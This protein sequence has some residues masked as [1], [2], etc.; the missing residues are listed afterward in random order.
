[1][2]IGQKL[3]LLRKEHNLSQ[4][5]MATQLAM[6]TK[7][8]GKIE[9]GETRANLPRLEQISEIFNM[10]ICELLSYG[11]ES[12]VYINADNNSSNT[13]ICIGNGNEEISRL[14]LIIA[15]KDEIINRQQQEIELLKEMNALLKNTK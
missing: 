15:H 14:H 5:E 3:Q 13:N 6:S 12:G 10:D 11:E 8:Y 7:G 2:K 4:E 9:R 1:M